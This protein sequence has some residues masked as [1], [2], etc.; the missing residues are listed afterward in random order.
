M[1]TSIS[2]DLVEA[3]SYIQYTRLDTNFKFRAELNIA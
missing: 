2:Y 1:Y 3:Y